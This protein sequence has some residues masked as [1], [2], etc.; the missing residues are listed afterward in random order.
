MILKYFYCRG[1]TSISMLTRKVSSISPSP[2]REL[3]RPDVDESL[4]KTS[5]S[6]YDTM[7]DDVHYDRKKLAKIKIITP[8]L[9]Y[10]NDEVDVKMRKRLKNGITTLEEVL[11]L[12]LDDRKIGAKSAARYNSQEYETPGTKELKKIQVIKEG[13]CL[14]NF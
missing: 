5:H 3:I 11:E 6:K 7:E 2:P 12:T 4:R 8:N 1:N 10:S 14:K 13:N 9:S